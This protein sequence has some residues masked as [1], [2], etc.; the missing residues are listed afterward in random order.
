[1]RSES[2]TTETIYNA[3]N[4]DGRTTHTMERTSA[5]SANRSNGSAGKKRTI[6]R[7]GDEE[8]V[9]FAKKRRP[10]VNLKQIAAGMQMTGR[11]QVFKRL[12]DTEGWELPQIAGVNYLHRN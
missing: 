12:S 10:Q 5:L 6:S 3:I 11:I 4:N 9:R 1:M 7:I 8:Y 2:P